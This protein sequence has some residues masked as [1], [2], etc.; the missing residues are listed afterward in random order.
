V[1]G[2]FG[3][4]CPGREIE[5]KKHLSVTQMKMFLQCPLKY[6]FRYKEGIVVRPN[7]SLTM[8]RCF[9]KAVEALYRRKMKGEAIDIKDAFSSAWAEESTLTDFKK[10]ENPGELKDEGIR[11]VE[12][13]AEEIAPNIRPKE[14]EKEFELVFDNVAYTLK[15]VIDLIEEDGTIV[16]HKCTKRAHAQ[17]EIDRDIQLSAYQIGYRSLY[18]RDPKGLRLD[19]TIRNKT[20][21]TLQVR[22]ERSQK[23][24]DRFLKLLGYVSNAISQD[25][26]YPNE[27]MM[28]STCGYKSCCSRW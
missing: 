6:F 15:G 2:A 22:T 24:L 9:H 12:K 17:A 5:M 21:K 16:D 14:V 25:L 20:P 27:T 18:G 11:L 7:S 3:S 8:G 13:Y 26:Y 4:T 19:F 1:G 23:D 28:C 10:D